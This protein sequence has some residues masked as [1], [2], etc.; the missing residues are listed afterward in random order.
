MEQSKGGG[1]VPERPAIPDILIEATVKAIKAGMKMDE[2]AVAIQNQE[3]TNVKVVKKQGGRSERRFKG[4][5]ARRGEE[6]EEEPERTFRNLDERRMGFLIIGDQHRFTATGKNAKDRFIYT[7]SP[8]L[9][10]SFCMINRIEEIVSE[11]E[12]PQKLRSPKIP[13]K[14]PDDR[15]QTSCVRMSYNV[16]NELDGLINVLYKIL[17][18]GPFGLCWLDLSFNAI[19]KLDEDVSKLNQLNKFPNG[20]NTKLVFLDLVP[21]ASSQNIIFARQFYRRYDRNT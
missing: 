14:T 6:D 1:G 4:A 15:Y 3:T 5:A 9:D 11:N 21:V 8:P 2:F 19:A 7:N 13:D 17:D 18:G 12:Q 10:Y 20:Q 16:I